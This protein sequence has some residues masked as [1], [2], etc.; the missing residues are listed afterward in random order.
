MKR[1]LELIRRIMLDTEAM[2]AGKH[3]QLGDIDDDAAEYD[4]KSAE[5]VA[6]HVE[7]LVEAGYLDAIIVSGS[8][9]SAHAFVIRR[10]TWPGHE[11]L[12][13]AKD[14][15]VWKKA[16]NEVGGKATS[17]SIAVMNALLQKVMKEFLG[18]PP[19]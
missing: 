9:G 7:L 16:L 19:N 18:L 4:G 11:F 17:I 5:E 12:A 3:L 10:L 8:M 1:D 6:A 14:D 15:V 13:N 2:P